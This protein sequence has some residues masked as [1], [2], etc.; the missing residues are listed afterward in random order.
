MHIFIYYKILKIVILLCTYWEQFFPFMKKKVTDEK[1]ST[2]QTLVAE[3]GTPVLGAPSVTVWTIASCKVI[4]IRV[5]GKIYFIVLSTTPPL[6]FFRD[7]NWAKLPRMWKMSGHNFA[8]ALLIINLYWD[9]SGNTSKWQ[10]DW[11]FFLRNLFNCTRKVRLS[12]RTAD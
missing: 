12:T 8:T 11:I 4:N 10:I 1:I 7:L 3:L 2:L 9:M 5:N 6:K